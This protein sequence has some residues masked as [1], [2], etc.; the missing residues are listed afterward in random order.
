MLLDYVSLFLPAVAL[1]IVSIVSTKVPF[2]IKEV[3]TS[4]SLLPSKIAICSWCVAWF[5]SGRGDPV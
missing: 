5:L 4:K 2:A 3:R 1:R